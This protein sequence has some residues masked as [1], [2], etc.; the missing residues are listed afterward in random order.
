MHVKKN[1]LHIG[2]GKGKIDMNYIKELNGFREWLLSNELPA[3]AVSLWYTLM[4]INNS[5]RWKKRFNAPNAIVRQ[6][7]GLTK[8][9]LL[10]ARNKLKEQ[11]LIDFEKGKRGQASVY[12]MISLA[13][14]DESTLYQSPDESAYQSLDQSQGESIG[15]LADTS[16]GESLGEF[17]PVLKQK[18]KEK[19]ERR[20]EDKRADSLVTIYEQN[21]GKLGPIVKEELKQWVYLVGE[22]IVL[23]AMKQTTKYGGRTFSYL[24]KIL[25]EWQ[26]ANLATLEAVQA[27]EKR[28]NVRKNNTVPF[29]KPQES[30][31]SLFDELRK[32]V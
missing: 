18:H 19:Q 2:L 13:R 8:Q 16:W 22:P 29:R 10:D 25:Q 27:Y 31:Q 26:E 7:S 15:L 23:E 24:E 3:N 12:E 20:K 1:A 28:K 17:R 21:I 11:G 14:T 9:G 32:E 5:A 6:L 4:S 30:K